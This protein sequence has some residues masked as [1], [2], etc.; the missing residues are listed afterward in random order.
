MTSQPQAKAEQIQTA[1]TAAR[2][3]GASIHQLAE[4]HELAQDLQ[5]Y[6]AVA[7]IR[8]HLR[9]LI[10]DPDN[11]LPGIGRAVILGVL[12]GILTHFTLRVMDLRRA[13]HA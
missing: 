11:S 3:G 1:I 7:E 10:P 2:S 6:H 12:G 5:L 8:Y 13:G 4:A 9:R